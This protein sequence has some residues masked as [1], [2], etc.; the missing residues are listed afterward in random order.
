VVAAH[1]DVAVDAPDRQRLAVLAE[2][3]KPGQRVLVV[4]VDERAVDVEDGRGRHVIPL[5]SYMRP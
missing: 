2:R 4:G 5:P 3:A 1:A